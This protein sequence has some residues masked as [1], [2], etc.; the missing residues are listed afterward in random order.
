[1]PTLVVQRVTDK[2]QTSGLAGMQLPMVVITFDILRDGSVKNPQDRPTQ[3]QQHAGFFRPPRRHGRRSVSAAPAQL[4]RQSR[5]TWN[6]DFNY[7]D[8]TNYSSGT[9]SSCVA[10]RLRRRT[11]DQAATIKG[12]AKSLSIAVPDFRG[13]GD[14]QNFMGVFNST[15]FNDLSDSGQLKMIPKTLYP[16]QV[17]QQPSDF[18]PP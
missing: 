17:P 2:W 18:R 6:S 13:S 10:S 7:S 1:M 3:R 16:M 11:A 12:A 4:Q 8:E 5:P 9:Q 14:A 15:L